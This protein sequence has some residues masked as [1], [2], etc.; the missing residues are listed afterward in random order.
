MNAVCMRTWKA[1]KFFK[2]KKV[3]QQAAN[4]NP[5]PCL[6]YL[7]ELI[8]LAVCASPKAPLRRCWADVQSTGMSVVVMR[9]RCAERMLERSDDAGQMRTAQERRGDAGQVCRAQERCGDARQ[10]LRAQE[11]C[12]DAG[13]MCRAQ[14]RCGDA[15]QMRSGRDVQNACRSLAFMRGRCAER[16]Q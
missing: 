14:Q 15:G 11:R 3:K 16:M 12:G 4:P 9:G 5:N 1:A 8:R 6:K 7:K 13:Q 10:M 2:Q